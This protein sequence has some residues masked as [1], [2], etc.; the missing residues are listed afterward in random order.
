LRTDGKCVLITGCDS[1]FGN[2][3]AKYLDDLGVSVIATC[4]D[5]KSPGAI[6]LKKIASDK[7]HVLRMDVGQDDSVK[8]CLEKVEEI[9]RET[10]LWGVVNN[11]GI[12]FLG[13]IELCTMKQ[14]L[15]TS[16]VNMYGMVR[17]T[18]AFLPLLRKKS[19]RIVNVT[20]VKARISLPCNSVYG[21]TKYGGDAFSNALRQE[22]KKFGIKVV[23]IEPGNFGG[24]TGCL[25]KE[26]TSRIKKDMDIMW[27]NAS[28]EIKEVYG[29]EYHQG[30]YNAAKQSAT[31]TCPTLQPVLN[32]FKDALLNE[33]PETRY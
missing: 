15:D 20:S 28:Q 6:E 8:E 29:Q 24:A 31:T 1:G 27:E 22:M 9:C 7:L 4:Y 13:D 19:G 3:L 30:L 33:E 17:V 21:I 11:A 16:N 12:N 5:D 14:Y 23:I 2:G 25:N 26:G 10:G 18:K 32:A